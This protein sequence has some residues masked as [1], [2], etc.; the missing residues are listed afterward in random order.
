MK[1]FN[2]QTPKFMIDYMIT[3]IKKPI[4]SGYGDTYK[5]KI[6]MVSK[7]TSTDMEL[8]EVLIKNRAIKDSIIN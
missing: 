4:K 7:G 5:P 3:D 1:D 8:I 2:A 6:R